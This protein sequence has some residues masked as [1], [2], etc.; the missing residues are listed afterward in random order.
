MCKKLSVMAVALIFLM[1]CV[2][3]FA[4]AQVI[5]GGKQQ[6]IIIVDTEYVARITSIKGDTVTLKDDKGVE[7]TFEIASASGL[8]VGTTA[9]CEGKGCQ[10]LRI[11]D[12][13]IKVNKIVK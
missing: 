1:T 8:K 3:P 7:R 4:M 9:R 2:V 12:K 13:L 11:A 5:K 10:E 6:G